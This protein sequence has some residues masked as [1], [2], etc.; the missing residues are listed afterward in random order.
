MSAEATSG[1]AGIDGGS[2]TQRRRT[3]AER[4]AIVMEAFA[5]G[6]S[7]SVVAER[8]GVS[9]ASIY[10]WRRQAQEDVSGTARKGRSH[11]PSSV[12]LVPVQIASLPEAPRPTPLTRV[13]R[14]EIVLA[15]G[16]ILKVCEGIDPARL[17]RLVAA[18][19]RDAP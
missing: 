3:V 10:L 2:E 8:H 6:Q 14:I 12:T 1:G 19:E 15:N 18:V 7:V 13:E 4:Q 5:E 11:P 16:R 17:A 9:T